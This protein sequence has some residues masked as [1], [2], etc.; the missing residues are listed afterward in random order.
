MHILNIR[1]MDVSENPKRNC[2]ESAL[3]EEAIFFLIQSES[4]NQSRQNC[5]QGWALNICYKAYRRVI[6]QKCLSW[7]QYY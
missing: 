1:T 4:N 5:I 2:A 7:E 6:A 3:I